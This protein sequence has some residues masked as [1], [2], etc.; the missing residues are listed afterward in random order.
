MTTLAPTDTTVRLLRPADVPRAARTLTDAFFEDPFVRWFARRDDRLERAF[1]HFLQRFWLPYG[2]CLITSDGLGVANWIPPGNQHV[3]ALEQI[4]VLPGLA[5]V[6]GRDLPRLMK[7]MNHMDKIHPTEPH[8]Y[9]PTIG[10]SSLAQ[11]RGLGSMLL[12]ART[13][14]LDEQAQ[15]AY[16]EATTERSMALYERHGFELVAEEQIPGGGPKFWPMWREPR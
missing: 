8:W 13:E 9:L 10:V 1:D 2:G 16:L 4:R 15:P 12:S 7:V 14:L 5:R 6:M 3:S 11:G